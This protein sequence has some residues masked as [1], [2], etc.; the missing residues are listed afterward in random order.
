M[1]RGEDDEGDPSKPARRANP[2]AVRK[3][4][5]ALSVRRLADGSEP[6]TA[7][8]G[9]GTAIKLQALS[10]AEPDTWVYQRVEQVR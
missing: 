5:I 1:R 3:C 4:H 2:G 10:S 9:A 6:G 8:S 7:A